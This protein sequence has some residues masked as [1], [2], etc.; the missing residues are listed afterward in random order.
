[1]PN[2]CRL[3]TNNKIRYNSKR[4]HWR[5]TKLRLWLIHL[6]QFICHILCIYFYFLLTI[7]LPNLIFLQILKSQ[8]FKNPSNSL[9]L[10][11]LLIHKFLNLFL[12]KFLL[13]C[14]KIIF[15]FLLHSKFFLFMFFNFLFFLL[16][17]LLL[18]ILL[19]ILS[20]HPLLTC[21]HFF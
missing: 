13:I 5:R 17:Y 4:R 1:M 16:Y 21:S 18:N 15:I 12:L 3:K 11:I 2:W 19:L 20:F 14:L 7:Y 10:L 8:R 9:Y 6:L